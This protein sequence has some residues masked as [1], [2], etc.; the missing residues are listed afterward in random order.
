[1][2]PVKLSSI[3]LFLVFTVKILLLFVVVPYFDSLYPKLYSINEFPD[4]YA[5][6]AWNVA[7]G[8][9]Y[10]IYPDTNETMIREPGYIYLL[11]MLFLLFG[12]NITIVKLANLLF[13]F[14]TAYFMFKMGEKLKIN[15]LAVRLAVLFF[16]LHPAIILSESRAGVESLFIT[17]V[18][19]TIYTLYVALDTNRSI[20][21]AIAGVMIGVTTLTRSTILPFVLPFYIYLLISKRKTISMRK[22]HLN[23]AVMIVSLSIVMSVWS[24]RNYRLAG[25][26]IPIGTVLGDALYTG[27]Y[28]NLNHF[29][30]KSYNQ[31]LRDATRKQNKINEELGLRFRGGFFATYYDVQDEI[32]HSN[33]LKK[34]VFSEYKDS[35]ELLLKCVFLNFVKFWFQG[36][37]RK[38]VYLNIL[39]VGPIL[40]LS[41]IGICLALKNKCNIQLILLFMASFIVVHLPVIAHSRHHVPLIPFLMLFC[42]LT[43]SKLLAKLSFFSDGDHNFTI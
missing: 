17:L 21:Y 5:D 35:P 42:G 28:T 29:D 10:R 14:M 37:T 8:A 12:K 32:K 2:L 13:S 25:T 6:I 9:G 33:E 15:K 26:F 41:F 4:H 36:N 38:T 3:L 20:H 11:A 7:S 22:I 16:L 31:L 1:M 40:I 18:L 39:L 24:V 34:I 23:M 27:L 43:L 30:D 19:I